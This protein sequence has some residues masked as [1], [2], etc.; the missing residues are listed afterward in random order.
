MDSALEGKLKDNYT[1]EEQEALLTP[2]WK[3]VAKEHPLFK[4]YPPNTDVDPD[5]LTSISGENIDEFNGV[6]SYQYLISDLPS[7]EG[8]LISQ[9]DMDFE[10]FGFTPISNDDII[11]MMD[12]EWEE[13][14]KK[15]PYFKQHRV[16]S[17]EDW[18]GI[19]ARLFNENGSSVDS[20]GEKKYLIRDNDMIHIN[21]KRHSS[22]IIPIQKEYD[23]T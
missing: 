15:N 23:L 13:E 18:Y 9:E 19:V 6:G 3:Q 17:E 10:Y 14:I 7:L 12:D 16:L 4:K 5:I 2:V 11:K 8:R 1:L 20:I 22:K 21:T